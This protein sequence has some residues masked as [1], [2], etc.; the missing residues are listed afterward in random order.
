LG[1]AAVLILA[2]DTSTDAVTAGFVRF[3]AAAAGSAEGVAVLAERVAVLAERVA[4][5]AEAT[6]PA[7]RQHGELLMPTVLSVC[8]TAGVR[9]AEVEAVV[10][11]VG[12]G[13]FT[14]L[15]VGLVSAASLGDA[16]GVPV[17]GVNSLDAIAAPRAAG[18]GLLV[19]A[20]ARR[21][22]LYWAAY[23]GTGTRVAG[24]AVDTPV[25]LAAAVP[26][27][28]VTRVGGPVAGRYAG[29]LGLT[30]DRDERGPDAAGLVAVAGPALWSGEPPA[31]LEPCYL[32]RP[33]AEV[34]GQRKRVSQ[35]ASR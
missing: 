21:R 27:L 4:V 10:C 11:G 22:E 34:P 2:V 1:A 25:A 15:R 13:P 20:D 26:G 16:L 35:P 7:A 17:F 29:T 33:D 12:P 30:T 19:V 28:G 9:L 24:P 18:S 5:L 8:Q 3:D 32:R 23:D 14:G 6:R 31:P